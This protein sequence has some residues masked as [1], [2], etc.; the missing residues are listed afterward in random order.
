MLLIESNQPPFGNCL[1]LLDPTFVE[2]FELRWV[3]G[4]ADECERP[5]EDGHSSPVRPGGAGFD[6][7]AHSFADPLVLLC[8]PASI[9]AQNVNHIIYLTL[10][11]WGVMDPSRDL[12][13][14]GHAT[15]VPSTPDS[16][17]YGGTSSRSS[18][19]T[20]LG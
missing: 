11:L 16:V 18:A 6:P 5:Q 17:F 19:A 9:S 12:F 3:M 10:I 13:G 14:Q 4:E 8:R 1:D 20:S 7:K 15:A 2:L